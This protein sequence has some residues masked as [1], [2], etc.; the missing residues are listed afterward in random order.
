M[1]F[2]S[3]FLSRITLPFLA[4][5][6]FAG[7]ITTAAPP[8]PAGVVQVWVE[9][10]GVR[11]LRNGQTLCVIHPRLAKVEQWKVVQNDTAVVIKS[12]T[13]NEGPAAVELFDISTGK[14]IERLMTF[15]LYTGRPSWAEG[16]QD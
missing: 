2:L 7:C 10:D 4:S 9:Q 6:L 11:V 16:F 14:L 12:R 15:S 1:N 3:S 13:N 5:V 8:K